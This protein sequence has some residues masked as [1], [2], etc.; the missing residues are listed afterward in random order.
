V[1]SIPLSP[2][3]LECLTWAAHGKTYTEIGMI[4]NI[5]F[6]TVKR[7]LDFARLKLNAVNLPHAVAIAIQNGL[8]EIKEGIPCQSD[9]SL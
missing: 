9:S 2:R 3:E 5:K 8:F 7:H 4:L 1:R 6:A